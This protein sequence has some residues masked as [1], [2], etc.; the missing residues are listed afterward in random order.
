MPLHWAC[1]MGHVECAR[2]AIS[3]GADIEVTNPNGTRPLHLAAFEGHKDC[4]Q[5]LL[6]AGAL[7][8]V[9]NAFGKTPRDRAED[10]GHVYI[11]SMLDSAVGYRVRSRSSKAIVGAA[12]LA[13]VAALAIRASQATAGGARASSHAGVE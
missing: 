10:A 4:V 5:L 12:T 3:T 13:V 7:A 1:R 6:D 11:V 8:D 2:L 9:R